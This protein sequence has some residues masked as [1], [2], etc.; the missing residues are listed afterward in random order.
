VLLSVVTVGGAATA[1]EEEDGEAPGDVEL[2]IGP[3]YVRR[4]SSGE[5]RKV[6]SGRPTKAGA[7]CAGSAGA[8]TKGQGHCG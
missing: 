2:W 1:R 4:G 5:A 6:G 8:S 3:F 7:R